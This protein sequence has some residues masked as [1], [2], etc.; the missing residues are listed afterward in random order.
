MGEKEDLDTE[1]KTLI[2]IKLLYFVT[3]LAYML[4][5]KMTIKFETYYKANHFP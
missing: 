3:I 2:I 5:L 1:I 4:W